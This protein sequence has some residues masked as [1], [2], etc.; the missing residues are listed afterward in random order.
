[1]RIEPVH[2]IPIQTKHTPIITEQEPVS[3][4][5]PKQ[6]TFTYNHQLKTLFKK[7]KIKLK[8]DFYGDKLTKKNCTLE[9]VE[10]VCD[11]GKTVTGN[12]VLATARMNNARGNKPLSEFINAE[13]LARYCDYFLHFKIPEFDG[14]KYIKELLETINRVLDKENGKSVHIDKLA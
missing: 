12:V 7:G 2:L 5:V 9:H 6:I 4:P 8:Y 14:V 11:G 10:C 13:A 1:M 3:K